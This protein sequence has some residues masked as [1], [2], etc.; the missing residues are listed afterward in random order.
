[1]SFRSRIA[2]KPLNSARVRAMK[3]VAQAKKKSVFKRAEK[4][5]YHNSQGETPEIKFIDGTINMNPDQN[6]EVTLLNGTIPG[7]GVSNRVGQKIEITSIEY[8]FGCAITATSL[9]SSPSVVGTDFM[10]VAIVYDK[11]SN[12]AALAYTDVYEN[13]TSVVSPFTHRNINNLDRFDVLAVDDI[14]F[15]TANNLSVR[16][17]RYIK[18]NLDV[19][20]NTGTAGT[21]ADIVSGSLYVVA[22]DQYTSG[23]GVSNVLGRV[24]VRFYDM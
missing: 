15:D 20:Y 10:R 21:I 2:N 3:I 11:Q 14:R 8:D 19:R 22:A 1:M 9:A 18:C 23:A 6:G 13:I 4:K 24:R 16:L 17:H 12:G 7:T 5:K